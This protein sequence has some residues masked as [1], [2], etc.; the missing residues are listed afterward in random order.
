MDSLHNFSVIIQVL[1]L[2]QV[3]IGQ[4]S[5]GHVVN[6]ASN[7]VQRLD[8]VRSISCVHCDLTFISPSPLLRSLL[9]SLPPPSTPSSS[10]SFPLSLLSPSYLPSPSPT[11]PSSIPSLFSPFP[12][13]SFPSS[14]PPLIPSSLL[15]SFPPLFLP[16]FAYSLIY[17]LPSFP[18]SLLSPLPPFPSQ[19]FQ[20]V[21]YLWIGPVHLAVFTYLLYAEVGWIAFLATAFVLLQI[22]LQICFARLFAHLRLSVM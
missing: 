17:F 4:I 1:T 20:F 11:I 18:L 9:S 16:P 14:L 15:P 8:L 3:T 12:H 19:T 5:I 10:L 2:S 13:H 21:Q 7:D 6:L 22:P